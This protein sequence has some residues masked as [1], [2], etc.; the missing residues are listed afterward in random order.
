[1]E[2]GP[3]I[4]VFDISGWDTHV[5]EGAGNGQLA[6]RL[7]ILDTA[8]GGFK[9]AL[10]P[11]WDKTVIVMATEFGRTVAPNGNAGTDH[12]T[13]GAAFLLGGNV[14]GGVVKGDWGGVEAF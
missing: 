14:Q 5:N 3:R 4:A 13:A 9:A 1:A 2:N 7:Q 6:R 10:G 12:G 8:L 11:A